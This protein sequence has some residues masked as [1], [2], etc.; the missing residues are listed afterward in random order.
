M[1]KLFLTI[2]VCI[3]F[4]LNAYADEYKPYYNRPTQNQQTQSDFSDYMTNVKKKLQK[5]WVYPDFLEEGH[6]RVLFKLDREGNVIAGDILE[7]YNSISEAERKYGRGVQ[8]IC[9][10]SDCS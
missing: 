10:G 7:S 9:K 4:I 8:E 1:G 3:S 2:L 5:N 6:V